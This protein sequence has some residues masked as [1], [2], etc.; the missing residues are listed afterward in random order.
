MSKIST[1]LLPIAL[2][3]G[4]LLPQL[5]PF[6]FL[7]SY[8]LVL[9]LFLAFLNMDFGHWKESIQ[10]VSRTSGIWIVAAPLSYALISLGGWVSASIAGAVLLILWAPTGSA[11]PGAAKIRGA[12]PL[13]V[14]ASVLVQHLL[15]VL[16]FPLWLRLHG[17]EGSVDFTPVFIT[18]GAQVLLPLAIA[19]LFRKFL[20]KWARRLKA[21]SPLGIWLW[22]MAVILVIA[23]ARVRL[24][25]AIANGLAI[26]LILIIAAIALV[27]CI[28]LFSLGKYLAPKGYSE[29]GGQ[30]MG[31]K[32]TILAIWLGNSWLDPIS[33]LGPT[34][35]VIWQ[36]LWLGFSSRKKLH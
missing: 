13:P 33:A 16:I 12:N 24:E 34:A 32:N 1:W 29:E 14:A 22:A 27:L 19:L 10:V 36:N 7:V 5:A 2:I 17:H 9:M 20:N 3:I 18:L 21:L 28:L 15:L 26:E 30:I 25:G 31:Q 8:F 35:Y 11:A 6:A 4:L 23:R